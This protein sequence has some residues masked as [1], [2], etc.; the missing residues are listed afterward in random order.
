MPCGTGTDRSSSSSSTG[1]GGADA[2][3][4]EGAAGAAVRD[5]EL[6]VS[7]PAWESVI[8][9]ST[10]ADGFGASTLGASSVWRPL[11]HPCAKTPWF[12]AGETLNDKDTY[13][14]LH[15][16]VEIQDR[17]VDI[18]TTRPRLEA[19]MEDRC[20]RVI[21]AALLCVCLRV[22]ILA[23]AFVSATRHRDLVEC[24]NIKVCG[25]GQGGIIYQTLATSASRSIEGPRRF[26]HVKTNLSPPP[27]PLHAEQAEL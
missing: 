7:F 20:A 4:T 12:G 24:V 14:D 11:V 6:Y 5:P 13:R 3:A 26:L 18:R 1:A 27:R 19:L 23:T 25:G 17:F 15:E 21:A 9:R 22:K 2:A 16:I 10:S 8:L